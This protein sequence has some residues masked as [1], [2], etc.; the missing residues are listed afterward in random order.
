MD[1]GKKNQGNLDKAYLLSKIMEK[2]MAKELSSAKLPIYQ[3]IQW[4]P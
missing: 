3:K 4:L 2:D 1:K